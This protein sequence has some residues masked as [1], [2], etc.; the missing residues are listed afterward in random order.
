MSNG[1]EIGNIAAV[2][3]HRNVSVLLSYHRPKMFSRNPLAR[4]GL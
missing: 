2:T 1:E 3:R 4:S